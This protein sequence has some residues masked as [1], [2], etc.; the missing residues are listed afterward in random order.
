[1]AATLPLMAA[2]LPLMAAVTA[3]NGCN[4]A[5]YNGGASVFGSKKHLKRERLLRAAIVNRANNGGAAANNGGGVGTMAVGHG[6][7]TMAEGA[8]REWR[9]GEAVRLSDPV[10]SSRVLLRALLYCASRKL[11][12]EARHLPS[13]CCYALCGTEL[14][15]GAMRSPVLTCHMVLCDLYQMCGVGTFLGAL[16][17]VAA[18]AALTAVKS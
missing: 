1:M 13:V 2:T 10:L 18:R 4:S 17:V 9:R 6:G 8:P 7:P 15:Y 12:R 14:A 16:A 3:I 5:L 11:L